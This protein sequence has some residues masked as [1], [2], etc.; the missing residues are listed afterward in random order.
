MT[1]NFNRKV[2]YLRLAVTD[3]CNLRCNYCMPEQGLE[4]LKRDEILS[5]EEILRISNLLIEMG[6]DKIRIT[7]GEPFLRK[8]ID[9]VISA[10]AKN[11]KLQQISITTNGTLTEPFIGSFRKWKIRSCNL[12]LDTLNR[13]T[14][15]TITRRNDFDNVI[16]TMNSLLEQNIELKINCVVMDQ[17]NIDSIFEMVEMTRDLPVSVR[18]IEEMPFNGD[19]KS[20]SGN[21]WNHQKILE[22]I[23]SKYPEIKKTLD[24]PNSTAYHYIVPGHKGDIGII[25][26]YTRSFCGSCNR[27]RLRPDGGLQTCLYGNPVLNVKNMMRS[28]LSDAEMAGFILNAVQH[29]DSDG[30]AAEKRSIDNQPVFSSMATIGG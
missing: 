3:R 6:V 13:D 26:A 20:F 30:W 27:I 1:D 19:L 14:F 5:Y 10:L 21:F 17:V 25:A 16:Q 18:F 11:D 7:G 28:G 29:R 15:R 9:M 12:S 2:N 4:W 22:H 24:P 23:R 8:D